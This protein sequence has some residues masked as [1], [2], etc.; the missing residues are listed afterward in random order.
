MAPQ[1]PPKPFKPVQTIARSAQ[2][3]EALSQTPHGMSLR[4]L[5]AKVNLPKG[6]TH[7]ILSSLS[8]Y[9]YVRRIL[10]Q[11]TTS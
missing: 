6:T 11:R 7:R 2:I 8:Y 9:G 5:S 10:R 3:L 1:T 4:D